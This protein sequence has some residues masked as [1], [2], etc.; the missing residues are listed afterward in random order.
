[1]ESLFV[2][3]VEF[4]G[5]VYSL[6]QSLQIPSHPEGRVWAAQSCTWGPG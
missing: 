4:E 2:K 1:M 6:L 5:D 3:Y